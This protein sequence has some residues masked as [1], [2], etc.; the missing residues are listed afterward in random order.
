MNKEEIKKNSKNETEEINFE[1]LKTKR[2]LK[3]K[4][5]SELLADYGNPP[6]EWDSDKEK[7]TLSI[8]DFMSL[9][10]VIKRLETIIE[11]KSEDKQNE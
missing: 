7:V 5:V 2:G 6:L 4:W 8:W 3:P 1:E 11:E 10:N 9:L